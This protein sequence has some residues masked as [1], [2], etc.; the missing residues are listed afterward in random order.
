M[1]PSMSGFE[2]IDEIHAC[3]H[4]NAVIAMTGN[5]TAMTR[6]MANRIGVMLLEKPLEVEALFAVIEKALSP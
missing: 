3:G 4:R 2:L 6:A 5:P 1:M